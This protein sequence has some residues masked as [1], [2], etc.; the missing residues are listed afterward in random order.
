MPP[1]N[2]HKG[3]HSRGYL[4]HLDAPGEIQTITIR[5]ADALPLAVVE[6]WKQELAHEQAW[7]GPR[8]SRLA[9]EKQRSEASENEKEE[10]SESGHSRSQLGPSVEKVL[11][12]RIARYEDAGHGACLL[13]DKAAETVQDALFYHDEDRYRLLEWCV[14]PNHVHVMIHC[15]PGRSLGKIVATW[16]TF[17]ARQIN[18][19]LSRSGPL[20]A[21]DYHD[22]YIRDNGHAALARAYIRNNPVKAGLC[23]VASEWPWSS[24]WTDS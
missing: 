16:K 4:P 8:A 20:W 9:L 10:K 23:S 7:L 22:R 6:R 3:W 24:G 2:P 13:R 19:R 17:S 21:D 15:A 14:M 12:E 1:D 11:R 18:A 5:L